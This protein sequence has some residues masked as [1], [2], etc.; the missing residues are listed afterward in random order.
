M[1][2]HVDT[3]GLQQ[4]GPTAWV[5]PA[6]GD[7][8]AINIKDARLQVPSWLE[9]ITQLRRDWVR[10][11][12]E[13]GCLIEAHPATLGGVPAL[14]QL[15]KQPLENA[16]SGQQFF[17]M[18]TLAKAQRYVQLMYLAAETGI[19]G[20]RETLLRVQLGVN[21][22]WVMP[23]PYAPEV[24]SKLPFHRGDDPAYDPQFPDHPLTRARRWA[25]KV[26]TTAHVDPA[27]AQLPSY[28][29]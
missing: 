18:F 6:N 3:A 15:S 13:L 23:H 28:Q 20:T 1:S 14:Y 4:V 26:A 29:R 25:T 9:D 10:D 16:P 22:P 2:V 11:F 5:D 17:A 19:T 21:E 8:F 27:F 7:R 12:S 24:E